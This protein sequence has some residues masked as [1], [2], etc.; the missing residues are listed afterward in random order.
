MNTYDREIIANISQEGINVTVHGGSETSQRVFNVGGNLVFASTKDRNTT[1]LI[2]E[3]NR[4]SGRS[5]KLEK[6]VSQAEKLAE[7]NDVKGKFFVCGV[8]AKGNYSILMKDMANGESFDS[9]TK[10]QKKEMEVGGII[11]E[12]LDNELETLEATAN[13]VGNYR[14]D[15]FQFGFLTKDS[16]KVLY[17]PDVNVK[18]PQRAYKEGLFGGEKRKNTNAKFYNVL[19]DSLDAMG[20]VSRAEGNGSLQEI[21]GAVSNLV[22]A[23]Q[24]TGY[25]MVGRAKSWLKIR[26][27]E[28]ALARAYQSAGLEPFKLSEMR[29]ATLSDGTPVREYMPRD[30]EQPEVPQTHANELGKTYCQSFW[31]SLPAASAEGERPQVAQPAQLVNEASLPF[32]QRMKSRYGVKISDTDGDRASRIQEKESILENI[33]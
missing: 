3:L 10:S 20:T 1:S 18:I 12:S 27:A 32:D 4:K 33:E 2:G 6:L 29:E 15:T 24:N 13:T 22:D 31:D 21:S 19:L 25:G 28:K 9:P 11:L 23:Y 5:V 14:P 30:G 16:T 26:K 17:D 8:N 7:G